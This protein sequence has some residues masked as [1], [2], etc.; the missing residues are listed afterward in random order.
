[1]KRFIGI[2]NIVTSKTEWKYLLLYE[3]DSE[4]NENVFKVIDLYRRLRMSWISYQTK[5]G[6]HFVGL[7]PIDAQEWGYYFK[8]LQN[9]APEYYS[10]QTLRVSLKEEEKQELVDASFDYPY[11]QKIA[12]I[13][14]KRFNIPKENIPEY[15]FAEMA[16]VGVYEKYW[17]DKI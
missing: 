4:R 13:Y 10:G 5:N 15:P 17:T 3:I 2:R 16:F 12:S 6:F 8:K 9:I 1:M 14:I 7:S 11:I